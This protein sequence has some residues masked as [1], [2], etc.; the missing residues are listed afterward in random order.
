MR[1]VNKI[2]NKYILDNDLDFIESRSLFLIYFFFKN[3]IIS[4]YNKIQSKDSQSLFIRVYDKHKKIIHNIVKE[5]YPELDDTEISIKCVYFLKILGDFQKQSFNKEF[6]IIS[7]RLNDMLKCGNNLILLYGVPCSGKST[8]VDELKENYNNIHVFSNDI[9]RIAYTEEKLGEKKDY[10]YSFQFSSQNKKDFSSYNHKKLIETLNKSGNI[11]IDNT[12]CFYR[13]RQNIIRNFK[14]EDYK[15]ICIYLNADIETLKLRNK[16]RLIE[17]GKN[18]SD[19]IINK[20]LYG[21]TPLFED[22]VD[23]FYKWKGI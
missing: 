19:D 15:K 20:F 4:I 23:Y 9:N 17:T 16:K 10:N 1:N 18:I 21:R 5:I 12:N 11:I 8:V 3:G 14:K 22:E 7:E 13:A 2:I 6:E